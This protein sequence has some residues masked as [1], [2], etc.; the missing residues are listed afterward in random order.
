MKMQGWIA[1]FVCVSVFAGCGP[2]LQ[3]IEQTCEV[4]A[5]T[6]QSINAPIDGSPIE[7]HPDR[8]SSMP[9]DL[10]TYAWPEFQKSWGLTEKMYQKAQ[11][12]YFKNA[13]R[14]KNKRYVTIINMSEHSSHKRWVLFDLASG[15][16]EK[17]LT[18]HGKNSDPDND[19]Y[20]TEFSNT[21]DSLQTSLGFYLTLAPYEGKYGYSMR[22]R[23]LEI[24]NNNAEKRAIVV[25]PASYVQEAF[26]YAGRSWGCPALDAGIS[27]SVISRIHSGSLF[28]I[29][30]M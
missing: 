15:N 13:D 23:G 18:T 24:T 2:S 3:S 28:Y 1:V 7:S 11:E 19:G 21:I 5:C 30:Q 25:H 29:A 9:E 10:E 4:G 16:I 22:L 8:D 17:Y 20:A 6:E 12:Y 27:A 14:I 26:N